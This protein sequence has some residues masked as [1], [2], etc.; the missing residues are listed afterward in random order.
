MGGARPHS[1]PG[2]LGRGRVRTRAHRRPLEGRGEDPRR[3]RLVLHRRD[4]GAPRRCGADGAARAGQHRPGVPV[5]RRARISARPRTRGP[6][7]AGP[8]QSS[9]AI[10]AGGAFWSAHPTLTPRPVEAVEIWNEPY[11]EAFWRTGPDVEEYRTLFVA[12][13]QAVREADTDVD[14][15]LEVVPRYRRRRSGRRRRVGAAAAVGSDGPRT[16]RLSERSSVS[17]SEGQGSRD[18]CRCGLRVRDG[19]RP[20]RH[21]VGRGMGGPARVDHRD[22]LP[23]CS[24]ATGARR[25]TTATRSLGPFT[26]GDPSWTATTS[27]RPG[28]SATWPEEFFMPGTS[29]DRGTY[30]AVSALISN[31]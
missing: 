25:A 17:H 28:N 21:G 29:T 15:G 3:L 24:S 10:A 6:T 5:D 12:A 11:N 4:D 7:P 8:R 27:S 31:P 20:A 16:D 14:I 9:S 30:G 1:A 2:R 26:S 19:R 13:A 23:V 22:R 18:R